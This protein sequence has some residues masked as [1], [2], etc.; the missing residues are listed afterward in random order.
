MHYSIPID[1]TDC[2]TAVVERESTE[3]EI[4]IAQARTIQELSADIDTLMMDNRDLGQVSNIIVARYASFDIDL[5]TNDALR[6]EAADLEQWVDLGKLATSRLRDE[7][8]NLRAIVHSEPSP[9]DTYGSEIGKAA[10]NG[11]FDVR[12][13]TEECIHFP[14][15]ELP[16][17]VLGVRLKG[18]L[19]AA[20]TLLA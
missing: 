17:K 3:I 16:P 9:P 5:Q 2:D 7:I 4:E 10:H 12:V 15:A 11:V 14:V 8:N 13:R 1:S 19:V 6:A 18:P 20:S